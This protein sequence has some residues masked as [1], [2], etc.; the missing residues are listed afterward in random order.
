[1]GLKANEEKP[2]HMEVKENRQQT[3]V[4]T[5]IKIMEYKFGKVHTF[6]FLSSPVNENN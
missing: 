6:A 3:I 5:N 1:M 4:K 2:K